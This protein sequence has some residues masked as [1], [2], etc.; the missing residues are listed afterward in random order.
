MAD[1]DT[2]DFNNARVCFLSAGGNENSIEPSAEPSAIWY[3]RRA[4]RI[5]QCR[6]EK[7][8]QERKD[9]LE[10]CKRIMENQ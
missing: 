8:E 4:A 7:V 10:M 3:W 1:L 5:W 2:R 6:F 9:I